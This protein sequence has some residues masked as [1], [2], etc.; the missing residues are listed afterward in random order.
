MTLNDWR[1]YSFLFGSST[2]VLLGAAVH[3]GLQREALHALINRIRQPTLRAEFDLIGLWKTNH[4]AGRASLVDLDACAGNCFY[5]EV[6]DSS[7]LL[8]A[9]RFYLRC[10]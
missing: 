6:A 2:R 4:V 9:A 3:A 5:I 8:A 7:S 10:N 1:S